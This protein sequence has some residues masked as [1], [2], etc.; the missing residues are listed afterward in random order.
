MAFDC[1]R[2]QDDNYIARTLVVGSVWIHQGKGFNILFVVLN[3]N[4][5]SVSGAVIYCFVR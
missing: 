3:L 4:V 1:S 5:V 2:E